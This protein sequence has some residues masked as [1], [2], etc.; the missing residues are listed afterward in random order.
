[1]RGGSR[2]LLAVAR[3]PDA[4]L[5]HELARLLVDDQQPA[6]ARA[7]GLHRRLDDDRE[8][9]RHVVRRLQRLPEAADGA[10]HALALVLELVDASL[11]LR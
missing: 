2:A 7:H 9:R 10:P 5:L 3:R 11:E 4:H 8:Q 1:M 6:A